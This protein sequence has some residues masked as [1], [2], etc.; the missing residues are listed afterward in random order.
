[1]KTQGKNGRLLHLLGVA[2]L[3]Y[4]DWHIIIIIIIITIT[5]ATTTTL[6]A[7]FLTLMFLL[8]CLPLIGFWFYVVF[9]H[10]V[11][12]CVYTVLCL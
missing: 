2:V 4:R 7:Y 11:I 12:T 5:T 9:I 10:N 3:L 6:F 8:Q 1:V